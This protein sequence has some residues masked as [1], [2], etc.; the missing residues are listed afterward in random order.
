[1]PSKNIENGR[2]RRK[3]KK[4]YINKQALVINFIW[5][6]MLGQKFHL[7]IQGMAIIT[8]SSLNHS[9]TVKTVIASIRKKRSNKHIE[10]V[11]NIETC[12]GNG[13]R[14][15]CK[16]LISPNRIDPSAIGHRLIV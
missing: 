2:R 3:N 5:N 1:M 9:A 11:S 15:L 7:Q 12:A 14:I 4:Y 6:K 10:I 16:Q 13:H 8:Q